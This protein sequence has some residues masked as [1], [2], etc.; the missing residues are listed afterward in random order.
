LSVQFRRYRLLGDF[1]KVSE[2][3]TDNYST[4]DLNGYLLPQLWEYAHTHPDFEF[5]NDRHMGLWYLDGALVA[6]ACYEMAL[7]E[8]FLSVQK[9]LENLR[10]EMLKWA[11]QEL[12]VFRDGRRRLGV[13]VTDVQEDIRR[14][15]TDNGYNAVRRCPVKI[16][17]YDRELKTAGLPEGFTMFSLEEDN[18][19][20]KIRHCLWKGFDHGPDPDDDIR[21]T[22]LMQSGMHFRKDLTTVIKAPDGDYACYAGVWLDEKNKYAYLE[23][24]VTVPKY[25]GRGLATAVIAEAIRKT[26]VLGATYLFGGESEIYTKIGF[27]TIMYRELW[28]REWEAALSPTES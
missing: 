10:P 13:W 8:A 16:F 6:V 21:G 12:S 28:A 11:E 24:L 26:K 14:L 1:E 27:E 3:L 17:P 2:F 5:N 9:G 19:H 18:D 7:G 22:L 4:A 25:R 20:R 15:L 23:P